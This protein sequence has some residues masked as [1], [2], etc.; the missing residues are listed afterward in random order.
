MDL[1]YNQAA[2]E[3]GGNMTGAQMK[4][5]TI[6]MAEPMIMGAGAEY[7]K[8]PEALSQPVREFLKTPQSLLE[9]DFRSTPPLTF[10]VVTDPGG[11]ISTLLDALNI[12]LSVNGQS[13][14]PL[15]FV[16]GL[17]G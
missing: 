4:E 8:N 5:M 9:I 6:A 1:V 11:D 15:K 3:Q 17:G 12:T 7:L 10:K 14:P 13:G 2:K 16:A